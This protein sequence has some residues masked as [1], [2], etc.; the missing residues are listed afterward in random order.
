M[1]DLKFNIYNPPRR[2]DLR[3]HLASDLTICSLSFVVYRWDSVSDF[4]FES[5]NLFAIRF[6]DFDAL[7]DFL[8]SKY[9]S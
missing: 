3:L 2:I 4:E 9:L 5:S 7:F 1:E 8:S 6:L